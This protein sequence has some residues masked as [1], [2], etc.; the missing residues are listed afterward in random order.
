M[1]SFVGYDLSECRHWTHEAGTQRGSV[2]TLFTARTS[3]SN[4]A[5]KSAFSITSSNRCPYK[6]SI[7]SLL[8]S[9]SWNSS[10]WNPR[11]KLFDKACMQI[12][13]CAMDRNHTVRH[14]TL[15]QAVHSSDKYWDEG[16][17]MR[18][19]VGTL[20]LCNNNEETK[21]LPKSENM[22]TGHNSF[23]HYHLRTDVSTVLL[24]HG[25]IPSTSSPSSCDSPFS[26]LCYISPHPLLAVSTMHWLILGYRELARITTALIFHKVL[27]GST[28][29]AMEY[30]HY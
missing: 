21:I 1:T 3:C 2:S 17:Q 18:I 13:F 15:L 22:C 16:Q 19:L 14:T 28:S 26:T 10:S 25:S 8:C 23:Q 27:L 6:K 9:I 11:K 29:W 30:Y 24:P 12:S 4:A 7:R 20:K 5:D